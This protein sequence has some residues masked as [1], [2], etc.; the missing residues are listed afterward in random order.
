MDSERNDMDL[1]SQL[2][3]IENQPRNNYAKQDHFTKNMELTIP[4]FKCRFG[5]WQISVFRQ[6]FN[7]TDLGHRYDQ[8]APKWEHKLKRY[9]YLNAY[10]SLLRSVIG[11]RPNQLAQKK[12]RVLDCGVG[13]GAMSKALIQVSP[14]QIILDAI[15]ISPVMLQHA[16]GELS[17][18]N[19]Q[20]SFK[21]A[22][23]CRLPY[24]DD[25]FDLVMS[26]HALEHVSNPILPITEMIRVLK[27]GGSLLI[28]LT[29]R[30]LLGMFIHF[31]WRTH[32]VAPDQA[33]S[34]LT[35]CGLHTVHCLT[36]ENN[37]LFK[38]LSV[39]CC[40]NKPHMNDVKRQPTGYTLKEKVTP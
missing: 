37:M 21:Q 9:N 32:W 34:W 30:S 13:T 29:R 25:I 20:V 22:D 3:D 40:G 10:E 18:A 31:K 8:A 28:C 1:P 11:S 35:K 16:T 2:A 27:P 19:L 12:L 7:A 23:M 4:V 6:A 5:S 15:D 38:R 14:S 33:K 36:P 39:A 17:G 24:D 26:A